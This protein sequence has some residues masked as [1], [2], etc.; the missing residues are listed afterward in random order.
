MSSCRSQPG[1]QLHRSAGYLARID[2][3]IRTNRLILANRFRVPE[4]NPFFAKIA[5]RRFAR[6][7]VMKIAFSSA[8][9]KF[10][11][12]ISGTKRNSPKR[13]ILGRVSRGRPWVIRVLSGPLDRL[14]A[15]LSL[16][17][18]L[19]RYRTP[20][21]IG[22]AIG[23]P[24]SRPI[25]HPRTGRRPQPPRSKPLRGAQPRD[26]GAIV[27]ETPLKQVRNEN[28]IEAAILNRVLDRD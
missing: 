26:S 12:H 15:I 16:L 11:I 19:D 13:K 23:R 27:S 14:N 1:F 21:A 5:N 10:S 20:S 6:S 24:L 18:P 25:S 17:Q 7:R 4:L 3:Q 2:S 22:S 9:A 8:N 28:A